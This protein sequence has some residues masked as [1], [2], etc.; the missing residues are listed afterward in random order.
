MQGKSLVPLLEGN[1]PTDWRDSLYYHYYEYPG[2]HSVRRHEG[3]FDGRWKLIKF[4]GR[5]MPDGEEWELY[6]VKNDP[7]EMNNIYSN[8]EYRSKIES[9]KTELASLKEQYQVPHKPY[10]KKPTKKKKVKAGAKG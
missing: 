10:V 9:M 4:Y 6:D 3:V 2:S 1:T 5:D 8:P 7:S